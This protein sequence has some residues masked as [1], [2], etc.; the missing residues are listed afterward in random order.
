MKKT[1]SYLEWSQWF[2]DNCDE[3]HGTQVVR[4]DGSPIRCKCQL[5]ATAK[6]RLEAV[7]IVPT[8][9]KYCDWSDF[10]GLIT[11]EGE[12]QGS[13]TTSSALKGRNTAFGYC[14][15]VDY[16]PEIAKDF[17]NIRMQE[18]VADGRNLVI[19][20]PGNS[21]KTLLAVLVLKE[22][23][24]AYIVGKNLQ[25]KW[26]KFHDI[27]HHASW[28]NSDWNSPGKQINHSFL[29]ELSELDFLFVDGI[30]DDRGGHNARPDHIS[31]NVLFGARRI[32]N[33]PNIFVCSSVFYRQIQGP[34][35]LE[36]LVSKFGEEFMKS[37]SN[38]N[39]TIIELKKS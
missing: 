31:M 35:G 1:L 4:V 23:C 21:G 24:N 36:E 5:R 34:K 9:L 11:N 10:T 2:A 26:T 39:N 37:V 14:F 19:V 12:I 22:A 38:P 13:L 27:I 32:F 25:F 3:C 20:G 16:D 7:D 29:D 17:T 28:A 33:L 18:R 6:A 15:G 8:R 30:D